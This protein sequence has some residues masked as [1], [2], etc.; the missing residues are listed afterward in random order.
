MKL[1]QHGKISDHFREMIFRVLIFERVDF[2]VL[3]M[4][5]LSLP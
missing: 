4:P 1:N 5:L 3:E 2:C